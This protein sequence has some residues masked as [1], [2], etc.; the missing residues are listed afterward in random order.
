MLHFPIIE[1]FPGWGDRISRMDR[2]EVEILQRRGSF[3]LPPKPLCDEMIE[4]YF[5]W[6]A[7]NMP[8]INKT[9]F[10]K[11]YRDKNNPPSL[12]LLQA[13]L[14][15]ASRVCSNLQLLDQNGSAPAAA[16][17]KAF[18]KRA[19]ALYDANYELDGV[20]VVQAAI[21]MSWFWEGPDGEF[22]KD[23]VSKN[24]PVLTTSIQPSRRTFCI[25]LGWPLLRHSE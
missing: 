2:V 17:A 7:P 18:Y 8:V 13:M 21:L 4:G 22:T 23:E 6:V 10:M 14:L 1:Q 20:T 25:G 12:L 15:A 19:K 16:A 11:Q 5:Q 3:L 9:R 24:Y